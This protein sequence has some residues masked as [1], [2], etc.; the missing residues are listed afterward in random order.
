M[1]YKSKIEIV[2]GKKGKQITLF[3]LTTCIWCEKTKE[4][5]NELGLEYGF[6]EFDTLE[7]KE[8]KEAYEE[9]TKYNPNV[10]FPTMIVNNGEKI[11][12]GFDEEEIRSLANGK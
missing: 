10:S 4:L 11:I 2:P 3:A 6:V 9:I 1:S 5:L 7:D 12:I 8:Q